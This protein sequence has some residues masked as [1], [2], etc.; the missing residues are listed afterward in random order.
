[1]LVQGVL[2]AGL[3]MAITARMS[4]SRLAPRTTSTLLLV[5][6]PTWTRKCSVCL[7]IMNE[8]WN[9]ELLS[10]LDAQFEIIADK[11]SRIISTGLASLREDNS[12]ARSN[13]SSDA[14]FAQTGQ[15][16]QLV[17]GGEIEIFD[18][19]SIDGSG[20]LISGMS[21]TLEDFD[22]FRDILNMNVSQS[23]WDIL[24]QDFGF[25]DRQGGHDY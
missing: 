21:E 12:A 8:R 15:P 18:P 13:I 20:P 7:A 22:Q 25:D 4:F 3:T 10:K 9:D 19:F 24:P 14:M 2:F 23:F 1:M 17:A 11:T 6:F 16:G 5:D